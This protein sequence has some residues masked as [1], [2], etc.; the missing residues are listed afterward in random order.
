MWEPKQGKRKRGRSALLYD[1]DQLR[2]D[3][4]IE[5]ST[6]KNCNGWLRHLEEASQWCPGELEL[7][8]VSQ[9]FKRRSIFRV[10]LNNIIVLA[11]LYIYIY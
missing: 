2:K 3:K 1:V 9:V 7:R 10:I 6:T 4:G 11:I 8:Q 5:H